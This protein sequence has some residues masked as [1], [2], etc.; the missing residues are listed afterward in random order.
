MVA[1]FLRLGFG[2]GDSLLGQ[3]GFVILATLL[4]R[5][6]TTP[7]APSGREVHRAGGRAGRHRSR[8]AA[9]RWGNCQRRHER[10]HALARFSAP[11]LGSC[12][13]IH[14]DDMVARP[15]S[16]KCG[17]WLSGGPKRGPPRGGRPARVLSRCGTRQHQLHFRPTPKWSQAGTTSLFP[18]PGYEASAEVDGRAS[19]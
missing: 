5:P 4:D 1:R 13:S 6:W 19:R 7:P 8:S 12:P 17:D 15:G 14:H 16:G 10:E 2:E 9:K 18:R 3:R 11:P